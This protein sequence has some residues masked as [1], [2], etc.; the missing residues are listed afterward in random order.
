MRLNDV[1]AQHILCDV[2]HL[3][4]DYGSHGQEQSARLSG[5]SSQQ[6]DLQLPYM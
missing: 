1:G 4:Q 5:C 3:A 2:V 6:Q